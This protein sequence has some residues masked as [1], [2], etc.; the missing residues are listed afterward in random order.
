MDRHWLNPFDPDQMEFVNLASGKVA[1]P[2]IAKDL[3]EAEKVGEV[4]YETFKHE[5]IE[6]DLSKQQFH[7]RMRKLKLKTFS[8]A[9]KTIHKVGSSKD[10]VLNADR[11][12]FA[13]MILVAENR[14]LDMKEVLSHPLGPLPWSLAYGDGSIRKTI[15][16]VLAKELMKTITAPEVI[17]VDRATI[18]DGMGLIQKMKPTDK[19]FSELAMSVLSQVIHE[20]SG[21]QRIDIAFDV[22]HDKSI[23][24]LERQRRGEGIGIQLSNIAPGHTI[25]QWKKILRCASSKKNLIKFLVNE[26]QKDR[27]RENLNDT[28]LYVTCEEKCYKLTKEASEVE[29]NLECFQEEAGTRSRIRD[30]ECGH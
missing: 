30:P 5:R 11:K 16:S 2:E 19:T 26:W 12:L 1:P 28:V 20:G 17:P 15:K 21:S 8:D 9:Y 3:L 25:Q 6:G 27:L 14:E 18:I 29:T 23:K 10:I 7:G 22:Y 24:D 4:A 13:H